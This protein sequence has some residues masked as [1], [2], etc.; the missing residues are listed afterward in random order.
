MATFALSFDFGPDGQ[1]AR[2]LD[3]N[4]HALLADSLAH[5]EQ[6]AASVLDAESLQAII[7]Q[8][9]A[10]QRFGP[11][12][13]GLYYELAMALMAQDTEL[14]RQLAAILCQ[15]APAAEGLALCSLND[16]DAGRVALYR[17]L[18]DTDPDTSFAMLA[19]DETQAAAFRT[20]FASATA[21][22]HSA[23]PELAAEFNGLIRELCMVVADPAANYQFDG[24]SSYMLWGGLFLNIESHNSDIDLIEV[25]A[26]ES[27]HCLLFAFAQD[28]MLVANDDSELYQSPLRI[29]PRPMDGI[30]HATYVSARMHRAMARLLA[31]KQ[32][33]ATQRA[34]A[35]QAQ[36]RDSKS[37]WAGYAV[38]EQHGRLTA[39]GRAVL[40][41]AHAYMQAVA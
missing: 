6:H 8:L 9:R 35:L 40:Q 18:M 2:W 12:A 37:F 30:Y 3:A 13:F 10:G 26:H 19:P 15:Q 34:H 41:Q 33:D 36:E 22:M 4:A 11:Y 5:I 31:S 23:I 28:E 29:D 24:G 21:L 27:A 39:T 7:A 25:L 14:A 20:R 38:V 17:R 32:L 1:R 16:L